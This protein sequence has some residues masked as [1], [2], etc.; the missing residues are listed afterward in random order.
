MEVEQLDGRM[1]GYEG[2][3]AEMLAL[4]AEKLQE[5]ARSI[6]IF[7]LKPSVAQKR[8]RR[9][10]LKKIARQSRRLNRR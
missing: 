1:I 10:T 4:G 9:K 5:G 6:R 3:V 7:R 2:T 8:A